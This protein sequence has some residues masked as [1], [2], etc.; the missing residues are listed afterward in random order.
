[1]LNYV[2]VSAAA[3]SAVT[4]TNCYYCVASNNKVTMYVL[5]IGCLCVHILKRS[6]EQSEKCRCGAVNGG[7]LHIHCVSKKF[8]PLNSLQ[9]C[10]ILTDFQNFC[11][12]GKRM[13]FATNPI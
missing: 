12:A 13:K 6:T 1:M 10:Q 4:K 11:T 7:L 3:G 9:L 8:P 2:E 5:M